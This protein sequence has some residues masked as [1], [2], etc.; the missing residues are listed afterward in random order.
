[1]RQENE[2][3]QGAAQQG[4]GG[5]QTEVAEQVA[6]GEEQAAEGT[7]RGDASQENGCGLVSQ[8]FFRVADKEVVDEY[9]Q[10]VAD[11]HAEHDGAQAQC[12]ERHLAFD[13]KD[14]CQ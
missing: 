7:Y 14:A 11:G 9:M 5:E 1:M 8:Q 6:V 4:E 10:G 2:G 12:H 3:E 13:P